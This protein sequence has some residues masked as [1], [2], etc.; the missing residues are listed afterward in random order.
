MLLGSSNVEGAAVRASLGTEGTLGFLLVIFAYYALLEGY[1][2]KP[3][4]FASMAIAL[5]RVCVGHECW[6][7][8]ALGG[9]R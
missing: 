3:S 6:D 8:S 2:L 7:L 5:V 9:F 1:V 4:R